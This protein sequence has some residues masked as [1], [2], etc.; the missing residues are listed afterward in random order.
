MQKLIKV[1]AVMATVITICVVYAFAVTLEEKPHTKKHYVWT[2]T[3]LVTV[4][5]IEGVN[6]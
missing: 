1:L 6:D 5:V 3:N 4:E 2:G